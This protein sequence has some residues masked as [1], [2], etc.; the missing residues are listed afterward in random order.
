MAEDPRPRG[1][2]KLK[3]AQDLRRVIAG[4]YRILYQI[5]DEVSLVVIARIRHRRE[6]YQQ[7]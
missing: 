7:L 4:D 5:Q 1:S 2:R 6:V 3:Q